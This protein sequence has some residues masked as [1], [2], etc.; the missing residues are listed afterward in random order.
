MIP[1]EVG[2]ESKASDL[3]ARHKLQ[4]ITHQRAKLQKL[5]Q[6][7]LPRGLIQIAGLHGLWHW[8]L[9]GLCQA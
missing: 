9:S 2:V 6:R 5:G 8:G 3:N 4:E 1:S 7:A